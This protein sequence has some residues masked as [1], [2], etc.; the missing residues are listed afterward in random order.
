MP[1]FRF[2]GLNSQGKLVTNEF[3]A[4]NK[5]VAKERIEKFAQSRGVRIQPI[6]QKRS[7]CAKS[8]R[9]QVHEW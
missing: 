7:S 5:K 2:K 9:W 3:E 6:D 8:Q 4:D 1:V